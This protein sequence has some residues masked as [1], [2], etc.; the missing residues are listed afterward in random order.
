MY[1]HG[2]D[3]VEISR[4]KHVVDRWGERFLRRIF[5]QNEIDY[6]RLRAPQLAVRFAAKEA[7]MKA[8]GTGHVGI[9]PLDIEVLPGESGAP[10]VRLAGSAQLKADAMGLRHLTVSLSHSRDYAIASAL[11]EVP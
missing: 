1:V 4:V 7:V 10:E 2:V 6:C 8:L 11:G 5:T 9:S 3:I